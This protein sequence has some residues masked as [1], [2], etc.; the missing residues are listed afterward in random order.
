MNDKLNKEHISIMLT[1]H[2]RPEYARRSVVLRTSISSLI[3]ST[4]HLPTEIIVVD[5]GGSIED[6]EYLLNLADK[7]EIT[8]YI[9]N[10][11]N[12]HWAYA[13]EQAYKLTTGKYLVFT[14]NDLLFSQ[15][16]LENC[17]RILKNH[18][19]EKYFA[20]PFLDFSHK[21][22]IFERPSLEDARVNTRAGSNCIVIDRDLYNKLG[23]FIY[24]PI[25]GTYWYDRVNKEL[26]YHVLIPKENYVVDLGLKD[27]FIHILYGGHVE[28]IKDSHVD[29]I[30]TNG[31][32]IHFEEDI[33][34][35]IK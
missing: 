10:K 7:G 13:W 21:G 18:E 32:V 11:D 28:R 19:G 25:G 22:R 4:R 15:G 9:R 31:D 2:I 5:N 33:D 30:L 35:N 14:S 20:T 34:R 29:K 3:A 16:W 1:H 23:R 24:H 6:S 17:I 8:T 26:G 12:L 27:G